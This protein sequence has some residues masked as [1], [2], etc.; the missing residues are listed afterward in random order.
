MILRKCKGVIFIKY[1]LYA[2]CSYCISFYMKFEFR[3]LAGAIIFTVITILDKVLEN[4]KLKA[5][6]RR[7]CIGLALIFDSLMVLGHHINVD[8]ENRYMGLADVNYIIDYS[9]YDTIALII[10]GYGIY[11]VLS[12][13]YLL[14]TYM[15]SERHFQITYISDY[16]IDKK[17]LFLFM[18]I[19][20]VLW[21]PYLIIYSPGFIFSDTMSSLYQ[22][23]GTGLDNHHPVLYTLFIRFCIN[24]GRLF[25]DITT[26][27]IVY[28]VCQMAY[29]A[30]G[31]S[32]MLCWMEARFRINKMFSMILLVIYGC[33][34]YIAQYSIAMWKDPIFSV[35]ILLLTIIIADIVLLSQDTRGGYCDK[36]LKYVVF[37]SLTILLNFSRNNG[38][39]ITLAIFMISTVITLLQETKRLVCVL[40][41][42]LVSLAFTKVVTG[43]VYEYFGINNGDER[44]ES[45]GIF[46]QQMAR[47]VV[48]DGNLS[49]SDTLW[50]SELL[51]LELYSSVYTP[52]CVDNMKWN[53][54]FNAGV[55]DHDFFK[56]YFSILIKNP[57]IC[58]EAWE[59]QTFG[60]WAVNNKDVNAWDSN[61][62]SGMPRNYYTYIEDAKSLGIKYDEYE[63]N[64]LTSIFPMV[65]RCI[66]IGMI[67]WFL[68]ILCFEIMLKRRW[69]IFLILAP[70]LGLVMTL[71][72][73]SP[74]NYWPR[75]GAAMQFML[76]IY[77]ILS[78]LI[79]CEKGEVSLNAVCANTKSTE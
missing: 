51:P 12:L 76:P 2:I 11:K 74:I 31:F 35:T 22:A 70:S 75:Y 64:Y 10:L 33:S 13:L 36:R 40:T 63:E 68:L 61:V 24:I 34:S 19:L 71:V 45:Y 6:E 50:M 52:C 72:I 41:I 16:K 79:L 27:C 7:L 21:M 56:T 48:C 43:S 1:L 53:G 69:E 78:L 26:G 59:L 49:E 4:N 47:V 46:L 42:C 65:S 62:L 15:I 18:V 38:L 67:T 77:V 29:M 30:F 37:F 25:G 23:L 55:L 8:A 3:G 44:V 73:A 58:F 57:K 14:I 60:F 32:Y 9:W 54:S 20:M 5:V 17:K 28:C 66:P 39:Y